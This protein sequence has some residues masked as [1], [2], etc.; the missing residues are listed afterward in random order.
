VPS[1]LSC[2]TRSV[3]D[4]IPTAS[5]SRHAPRAVAGQLRHAERACYKRRRA[6]GTAFPRGPWERAGIL[7][8]HASSAASI[9]RPGP[10]ARATRGLGAAAL[11]SRSK[12]NRIV[13]DD[14]LPNSART[15]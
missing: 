2:G 12:I 6:S 7:G 3:S 14:M 4:C 8:G 10:K 1:Q 5:R 11:R 9:A 13:G 15:P